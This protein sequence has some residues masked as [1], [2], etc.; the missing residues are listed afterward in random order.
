[1]IPGPGCCARR[2][3]FSLKGRSLHAALISDCILA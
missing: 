2:L 1:M 3:L